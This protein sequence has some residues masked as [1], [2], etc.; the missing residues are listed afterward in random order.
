[1]SPV[2]IAQNLVNNASFENKK[3][4][5]VSYNKESL[6]NIEDWTQVSRGTPDYFH[7]CS[8]Q[9]GVPN[10]EFGHQEAKEGGAYAGFVTFSSSQLNYREYIQSKLS[11]PLNSGEMICVEFYVSPADQAVFVTDGVGVYFS[12]AKLSSS[13][14][15]VIEKEAQ[16][17]NPGLNIIDERDQ[18]IKISDTFIAQG[19]EE[20]IIIGNF[21]ND[22]QQ[23]VLKRSDEGA[24]NL[25]SNW[26]YLYFDNLVVK[27]V[28]TR[29]ACSCV[30]DIIKETVHDPPLELD[31][32]R[33]IQFN[34]ILF[35]FDESLITKDAQKELNKVLRVLNRNK[36]FF[37]EIIG[38][39]DI[40]GPDGYNLGLS[41]SRAE[42]VIAYFE[43][44][45]IAK[46]RLQLRFHGS[47]QP[48][49]DNKTSEGRTQNRRVEFEV[50]QKIFTPYN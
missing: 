23:R 21:K 40:V 16:V 29:E 35:D 13:E 15:K 17:S 3:Y 25:V 44:R 4:C 14:K 19:G 31:E 32:V 42:A 46:S 24:K 41:K 26:A 7:E 1:M 20:F 36:S 33:K 37:L 22:K 18:W 12:K 48:V 9:A 45:G 10:N 28:K 34:S 43:E 8:K 11:R 39:A 5:P 50:M 30:N 27:P 49:A 38:H 2:F 6:K 47:E